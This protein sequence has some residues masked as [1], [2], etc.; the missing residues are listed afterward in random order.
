MF[1]NET[2]IRGSW[3]AF[4]R[5]VCRYLMHSG[6]SGIRLVGQTRDKGADVIA[7]RGGKRWLIQV[8]HWVA[9]IGSDVIDSTLKSLRFY[10]ADIP[11]IVALNGFLEA[12]H[13]QQQELMAQRIPLQLWSGSKLIE[14]TSALNDDYPFGNPTDVF[15]KREY[16]ENAIQQLV[17]EYSKP[18]SHRAL[19]VMA[20]GLGKTHVACEFIRR[21]GQSKPFRVL[22]LAHTNALVYQLERSFWPYLKASQETLVWNAQMMTRARENMVYLAPCNH[23]GKELDSVMGGGSMIVDPMGRILKLVEGDEGIVWAD[24]D[25]DEVRRARISHTQYRDRRPDLYKTITTEMDDLH[26]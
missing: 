11:V 22:T 13:R 8:K 16:Q 20:T 7:H 1:F 12:A 4:E 18:D 15:E 2:N 14:R 26:P 9:K 21:I 3:Q 25:L 10:R 19:V 23:G 5:L 6:Y 24:L 17:H